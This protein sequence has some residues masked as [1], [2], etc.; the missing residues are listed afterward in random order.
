VDE[1]RGDGRHLIRECFIGYSL[2]PVLEIMED[3]ILRIIFSDL[4]KYVLYCFA[5]HSLVLL[6]QK[7]DQDM[8]NI[9]LMPLLNVLHGI[10]YTFLTF[11][12]K[13]SKFFNF[14]EAK[15]KSW[16]LKKKN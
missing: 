7:K 14:N 16:N 1:I 2:P 4:E 11:T 9:A 13:Q 10:C 12:E 3:D 6:P 8:R 5:C 15:E